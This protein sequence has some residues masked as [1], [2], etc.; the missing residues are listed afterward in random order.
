[1]EIAVRIPGVETVSLQ[2]DEKNQLTVI[3]D[4]IDAVSLTSLLRKKLGFAELISLVP[5]NNL[6]MENWED[7][8]ACRTTVQPIDFPQQ[9]YQSS[10][11]VPPYYIHHDVGMNHHHDSC[12]I[13]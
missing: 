1:M 8:T 10:Y 6:G 2:G 11:Y 13:L 5:C 7:F 12:V 3:G 4:G 9:S